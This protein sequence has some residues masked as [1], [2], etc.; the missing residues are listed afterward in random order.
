[1]S[2]TQA[3]VK[4]LEG[5][6]SLAQAGKHG[7]VLDRAVSLGG[8]EAGFKASELLLLSLGGC[9]SSTLVGVTKARNLSLVK[10][11]IQL[12][13]KTVPNPERFGEIEV[14]VDLAVS[15]T[16]GIALAETELDKLLELAE[17]GCFVTNTLRSAIQINIRR[18]RTTVTV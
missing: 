13:G 10:A 8:A 6:L 7:V 1:M 4:W 3:R 16:E 12:L 5:T 11:D 17:R 9:L 2:E 15:D 18:A 14:E